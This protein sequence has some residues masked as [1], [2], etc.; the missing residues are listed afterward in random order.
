VENEPQ[1][2]PGAGNGAGDGAAPATES[3]SLAMLRDI[4]AA[5]R[6]LTYIRS[7]EEQRIGQL[8]HE[9]AQRFF[10]PAIPVWTWSLTEGMQRDDGAAVEALEPRAALDFIATHP[11]GAIFHLKD[12]HEP[13]RA[14]AEI[15]RRLRDLY[16][17]C[18]DADKFVV[19]SSP[20]RFIP[21][22]VA[23][24]LVY[25]ELSLPDLV[26]L[27][28]FLRSEGERIIAAGGTVESDEGT[29]HQLAQALQGLTLD[30]ARH[31][32]RRALAK[33]QMLGSASVPILLEEKRL[34]VNR[35]GL[36]ECVADSTDIGHVG[37]LEHLKKWL[38][39]R[40]KLF[41]MRESIAADIVPKG[42]LIMGISGCGKSLSIKAIASY[43]GL[44]LYRINMTD[45]FS[46]AHGPAEA[47]FT[48]A[49]RMLEEIAPAVVWFDE[50]EMGVASQESSGE[51]GRMFAFF[52][53]WMQEK[54]RGVFVAATANRIDLLP[55]EMIRKGRFDEVF[56]VDLP[57]DEERVEIFKIHLQRRGIDPAAFNFD[58]VKRFTKGWT[59]AE[60][61]QCVVSALSAA[62][63]LDRDLNDEDLQHATLAVVP[64]SKTM[65]EQVEHIRT[66]AYARAAR[67]S[68]R[69]S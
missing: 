55:A 66:W 41:A 44:P 51:Q 11:G 2:A 68:P 50:I 22:D 4:F 38:F 15:R 17:C 53:T 34:F 42:V 59:G 60:I 26:E 47:A 37:G 28:A 25:V 64:L 49:C 27:Q 31:A 52:L 24:N 19:I 43:F 12:F 45:I 62:R 8:L 65:R 35:S 54:A 13:M 23:R 30:E 36:V 56:F 18:F 61:E 29:L 58:Q 33:R 57:S 9:A 20:I 16:E 67:A 46:G 14:A 69:D 10:M 63:L 48:R 6:P 1:R 39:E 32:V 5:G 40:R 7:A 3:R 21:E